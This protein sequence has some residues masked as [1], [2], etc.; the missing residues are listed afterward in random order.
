M[1]HKLKKKIRKTINLIGVKISK[2][3]IL[4]IKL[5]YHCRKKIKT[6]YKAQFSINLILNDK[7][8]KNSIKKNTKIL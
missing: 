2:P 1:H 4:I 5:K 6:D 8:K 7:I 3:T